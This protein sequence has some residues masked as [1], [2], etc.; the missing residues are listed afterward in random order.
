MTQAGGDPPS[1]DA[2]SPPPTSAPTEPGARGESLDPAARLPG[3]K[4]GSEYWDLVAKLESGHFVF[5]RLLLTNVGPGSHN[6]V[7]LGHVITPDGERQAFRNGRRRSRWQLSDDRLKLDINKCHLDLHDDSA[8]LVVR[9]SSV[10]LSLRFEL[11]GGARP[12]PGLLPDRYAAETLAAN[13]PVQG[14]L[15]LADMTAPLE[16]RGTGAVTHSWTSEPEEERVVRR[17]DFFTLTPDLGLQ[18]SEFRTPDG[19]VRRWLRATRAGR[20]VLESS[21]IEL[22][23]S[24][25][26][27]GTPRRYPVEAKL[28]LIGKA[29]GGELT[30]GR[31]LHQQDPLDMIPQPLRGLIRWSLSQKPHQLWTTAPYDLWLQLAPGEA[32]TPLRGEGLA[33]IAFL[34]PQ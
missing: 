26:L 19:D 1:A 34:R 3:G 13:A 5:A 23:A 9:K 8:L 18:L 15:K 16:I 6:A 30:L 24:G 31:L 2:S 20:T 17:L 10:Q 7:M 14:T 25:R 27:A 4:Q 12:P 28:R 11:A 29:A 32:P 22:D 21:R 33:A